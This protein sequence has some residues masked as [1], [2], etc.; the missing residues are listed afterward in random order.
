MVRSQTRRLLERLDRQSGLSGGEVELTQREQDLQVARPL[1]SQLLQSLSRDRRR[2]RPSLAARQLDSS[3]QP[4]D[5][6]VF[7]RQRSGVGDVG[8]GP[9]ETPL[10]EEDGRPLEP[11]IR[12]FRRRFDRPLELD[13]GLAETPLFRQLLGEQETQRRFGGHRGAGV[14]RQR[15]GQQQRRNRNA[16]HEPIIA[17]LALYTLRGR[18]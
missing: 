3:L 11:Q 4:Q 9:V 10:L 5:V 16:L 15:E 12:V 17:V 13:Q 1:D 2:L 18:G 14:H 6:Q 7:R 8:A